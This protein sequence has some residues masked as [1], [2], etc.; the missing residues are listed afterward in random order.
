MVYWFSLNW[1]LRRRSMVATG[2]IDDAIGELLLEMMT[3]VTLEVALAVQ[4]ELQQRLDDAD[5]LRQ[6]QVERARYEA[7]LAQR[8]YLQVDPSNRL[9]ADALEADWNDKLRTLTQAQDNCEKQKQADRALLDDESRRQILALATDFPKLWRDS[10]TSDRER[11]RIVR[12]L[13]EDVTLSKGE[14]ITAEV[15]FKG[16]AT[17]T[18]VV[19]APQ[20]SWKTWLTSREVIAEID[21]LLD[22]H[23]E[24]EIAAVLNAG[25]RLSGKGYSFTRNLV[26]RLRRDYHLKSRFDRLR[27]AG[28][29]TAAEVAKQLG[30]CTSTVHDWRQS[31]LLKALPF[32]DKHEYLYRAGGWNRR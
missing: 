6:Q 7:D 28:M 2:S 5:R 19:S 21:R 27:D 29:L 3:L 18:Q 12:L 22:Q 11:K 9:V 17:R 14:S 4:H 15:R 16:G 24:R 26:A 25:H 32:S 20:P 23:T 30:V 1:N 13:I 8:R 10:R 31:G